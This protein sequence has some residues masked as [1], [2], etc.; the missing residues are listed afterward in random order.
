MS[1]LIRCVYNVLCYLG[2]C[3]HDFIVGEMDVVGVGTAD[4]ELGDYRVVL[5]CNFVDDSTHVLPPCGGG[6]PDVLDW[7]VVKKGRGRKKG[8]VLRLTWDVQR[9]RKIVWTATWI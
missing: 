3:D 2:L 9:A 6:M 1:W 7:K 8:A 4:V 5:A